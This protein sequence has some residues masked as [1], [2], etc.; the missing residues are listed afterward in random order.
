FDI[1]AAIGAPAHLSMLRRTRV[2]AYSLDEARE[3]EQVEAEPDAALRPVGDAVRGLPAIAL[4]EAGVDDA[5]HGRKI[6]WDGDAGGPHALFA[7][8][9]ALVAV[10]DARAGRLCPSVVLAGD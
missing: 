2:G 6:A 7:P 8:D 10:A 1:G 5:R 3:I 4:D 9:G